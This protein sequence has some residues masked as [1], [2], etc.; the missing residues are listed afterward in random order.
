[1]TEVLPQLHPNQAA[2][3]NGD[4]MWNNNQMTY[5]I[6]ANKIGALALAATK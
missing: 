4:L 6:V 2:L 3:F 5:I 1:M